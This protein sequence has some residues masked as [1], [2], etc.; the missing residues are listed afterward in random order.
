MNRR[1]FI[2]GSGVTVLS[3][4]AIDLFAIGESDGK[5]RRP[6]PAV[7]PTPAL[8]AIACGLHAP[9]PHNTQ[10][11]KFQVLTKTK[12]LFFID[13]TRILP[14]T[15][16]TTRQVHIGCGAFL[17]ALAIGVTS[18]GLSAKI[19]LFPE[20]LTSQKDL[21]PPIAVV[22]IEKLQGTTHALAQLIRE[23]ATSRLPYSRPWERADFEQTL[24]KYPRLKDQVRLLDTSLPA[25]YGI[26]KG[27]MEAEMRT[28]RTSEESRVWFRANPKEIAKHGDGISLPGLGTTGTKRWLLETFVDLK[29]H[30]EWFSENTL[31]SV[32]QGF[33]KSLR[34]TGS[35]VALVTEEN[36]P[37]DWVQ[38]GRDYLLL[39]TA[40]HEKGIYFHPLSQALQ[41]FPEVA[42]FQS[43]LNG[44]LGI[45]GQ[46][47][48]QMF[49]RAGRS[50]KPWMAPRRKLEDLIQ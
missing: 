2:L 21:T 28:K 36:S 10:A 23:R 38:A 48:I 30:D 4:S 50:E 20:G 14:M 7:Q 17:E 40:A 33:E 11:W 6:D 9:N 26:A 25:I 43:Q 13:E 27:A 35:F 45:H 41:E 44:L 32:M 34:S 47:K 42:Q 39:Q 15:D 19:S 18:M 49:A 31:A 37:L 1:D 16:P 3:V 46:Q 29:S 22:E 8:K 12:F 24:A 5:N